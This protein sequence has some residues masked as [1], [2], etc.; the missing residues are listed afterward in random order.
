MNVFFTESYCSNI[1]AYQRYPQNL[2]TKCRNVG[3]VKFRT[4]RRGPF[5]KDYVSNVYEQVRAVCNG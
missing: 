5:V 1:S 3:Y 4:N 2:A